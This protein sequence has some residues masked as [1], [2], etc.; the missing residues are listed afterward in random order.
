MIMVDFFEVSSENGERTPITPN[1]GLKWSLTDNN[2]TAI[3]NRSNVVV[4]SAESVPIILSGLDLAIPGAYPVE[5]YVT[6]EGTYNSVFSDNLPIK[7]QVSFQIENLVA[8]S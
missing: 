1:P 6:V 7:E 8:I 2:G 5:R 3:N 4:D